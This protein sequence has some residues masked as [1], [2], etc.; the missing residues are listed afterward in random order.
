M[1]TIMQNKGKLGIVGKTT[2]AKSSKLIGQPRPS[3]VDFP[4]KICL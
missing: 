4:A 2:I 3:M 1:H